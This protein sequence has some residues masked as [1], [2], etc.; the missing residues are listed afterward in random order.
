MLFVALLRFFA[1]VEKIQTLALQALKN[2]PLGPEQT[3]W[4]KLCNT[5]EV[6]S[7]G[8]VHTRPCN[9]LCQPHLNREF[10]RQCS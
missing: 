6:L 4:D 3:E 9:V 8:G 1:Q 10:L 5:A 2:N 7:M